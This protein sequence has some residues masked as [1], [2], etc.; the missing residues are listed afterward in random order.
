MQGAWLHDLGRGLATR[1]VHLLEQLLNLLHPPR[2]GG[3]GGGG[4][5][6]GG[7]RRLAA[8]SAEAQLLRDGLSVGDGLAEESVSAEER[9]E[10]R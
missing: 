4:S 5:A 3:R 9:S 10:E 2:L 6:D 8:T 7:I 1:A